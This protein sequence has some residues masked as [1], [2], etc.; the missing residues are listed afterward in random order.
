MHRVI[1][2]KVRVG[3]DGPE[4]IDRNHLDIRSAVFD[5]GPENVAA[6]AA[7]SIDGDVNGHFLRLPFLAPRPTLF[8]S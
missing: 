8:R 7:E 5:D 1:S 4:I 3:F 2:Q 6:D